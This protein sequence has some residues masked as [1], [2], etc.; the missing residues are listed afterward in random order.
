MIEIEKIYVII[1][2]QK[3][4]RPMLAEN[5][6][7]MILDY[8]KQHQSASV[9][10][11]AESLN[12][13]ESTIRRD[14]IVLNDNGKLEKVR[15]GAIINQHE[16]FSYEP[17]MDTKEA[18]FVEEKRRM[19]KYAASIITAEDFVFIDA[20]TSTLH[21][22][23]EIDGDALNAVYV[24]TGL[25]HTRILA[26]KGCRVYVPNGMVKPR[27]EAI[28]GN[29]VIN[30]LYRYNFTKAFIGVNGITVERGFT[31][32]TIEEAELKAAV[33]QTAL[34]SWFLADE[35][36][37]N[38]IYAAGICPIGRAGIITNRL[39]DESYRDK[40]IIKEIDEE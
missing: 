17:D 5:R 10:Q 20:G 2:A 25:A 31:T 34:E 23:N 18:L 12:T 7:K 26:R 28:V 40:T 38:K 22:A 29:S 3:G 1:K 30:N 9:Q 37:F 8:L 36:K 35:S 13:S 16:Y 11:L 6:H 24:T 21:L 4:E 27:T 14:L 39:T 33:I 19:G 32:P 15:G